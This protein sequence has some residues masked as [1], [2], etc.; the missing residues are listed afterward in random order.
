MIVRQTNHLTFFTIDENDYI[1]FGFQ[2]ADVF[3][4]VRDAK[5]QVFVLDFSPFNEKYTDTLAFEWSDLMN[6]PEVF[7]IIFL[8]N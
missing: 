8:R 3:D 5:D 7:I 6:E 2:L 4:V 1:D